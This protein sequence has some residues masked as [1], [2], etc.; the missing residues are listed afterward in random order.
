[1]DGN[2][3]TGTCEVSNIVLDH[4]TTRNGTDGGPGIWGEA[5]DIT[6]SWSLFYYNWNPTAISG[7]DTRQRISLHHNVYAKNGERNPQV[8]FDT[9]VLDV[10]NNIVYE[11]GFFG[12]N[13]GYGTRIRNTPEWPAVSA[14]IV[15]NVMVSKT[16]PQNALIYGLYPGADSEETPPSGGPFSQGTIVAGSNMGE[17]YVFGN[18]LPNENVDHYSTIGRPLQIPAEFGVTLTPA[19][20]LHGVLL[21]S[22]GMLYRL[23]EEEDLLSEI[24]ARLSE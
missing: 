9:Q 4:I 2:N 5:H 17:L 8:R 20:D 21:P 13:S 11:W 3:D 19:A 16:L 22:V 24:S 1:M 23:P 14:N 12:E 10:V 18:I 6:I 7:P 15:G